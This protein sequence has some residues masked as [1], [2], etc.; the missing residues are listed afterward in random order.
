MHELP[1]LSGV[2]PGANLRQL[3]CLSIAIAC[4]A[5]TQALGQGRTTPIVS[6]KTLDLLASFPIAPTPPQPGAPYLPAGPYASWSDA[7]KA[8]I[9]GNIAK[10]CLTMWVFAHDDPN[11]R[12]LPSEVPDSDEG[13]I[14]VDLCL[15]GH[16]PADWPDRTARLRAANA[17]FERAASKGSTLKMPA[18]VIR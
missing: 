6:Q 17:I 1:Q 13:E 16:M 9:P 18:A 11:A 7:D 15:L 4:L 12:F 3:T 10:T 14:G 8:S 2:I 5:S